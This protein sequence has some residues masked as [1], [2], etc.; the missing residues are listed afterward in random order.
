MGVVFL[1]ENLVSLNA[2]SYI[3]HRTISVNKYEGMMQ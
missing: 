1:T 2:I 3:F